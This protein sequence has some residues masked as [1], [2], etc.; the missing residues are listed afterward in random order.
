M[1]STSRYSRRQ[2]LVGGGVAILGWPLRSLAKPDDAI[3]VVMHPSKR[4]GKLEKKQLRAIFLATRTMW[5]DGHPIEPL[6]LVETNPLRIAFDRAVLDMS[7]EEVSRYW[8]DRKI[9][10]DSRPPRRLQTPSAVLAVVARNEDSIGYLPASMVNSTV[11]V[12]ARVEDNQVI[13]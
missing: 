3:A 10:G 2:V 5:G 1:R 11:Q 9:R 12:V 13:S 6:N 4:I 7:P 8:I